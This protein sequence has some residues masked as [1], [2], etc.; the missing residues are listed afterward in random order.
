MSWK[1]A[2]LSGSSDYLAAASIKKD[3]H[4]I[5]IWN[6]FGQFVTFLEGPREGIEMIYW[7]PYLPQITVLT[8]QGFLK[9]WSKNKLENWSAL[10]PNF[11]VIE[12]NVIY[13]EKEDEFDLV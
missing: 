10:A 11:K 4:H 8:N 12:E 3:H 2:C 1:F 7:H 13:E 6:S 9:V 5:Y